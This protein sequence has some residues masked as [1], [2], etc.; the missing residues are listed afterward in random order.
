VENQKGKPFALLGV[1]VGGAS[2]AVVKETMEKNKLPWRTFVD[3]GNAGRGPIATSWNHT[4]TPTFYLLDAQG[5]I[6]RK[7]VGAPDE[8]ALDAAVE[9]LVR[10]TEERK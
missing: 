10:E 9:S 6:R 7:W 4:A 3:P 5:I 1:H 8:K 2:T